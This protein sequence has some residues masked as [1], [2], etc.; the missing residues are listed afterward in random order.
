MVATPR[1]LGVAPLT[2]EGEA[3][4]WYPIFHWLLTSA[5]CGLFG[6]LSR[7]LSLVWSHSPSPL[8]PGPPS[9]EV[10][11]QE[12]LWVGQPLVP[13]AVPPVASGL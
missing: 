8:A 7:A 10:L 2:Y 13:F 5:P 4:G 11:S 6:I 9:A 3:L 1:M 12:W